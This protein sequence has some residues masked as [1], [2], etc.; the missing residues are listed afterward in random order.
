MKR[1][2]FNL[3]SVLLFAGAVS[4]MLIR[5]QYVLYDSGTRVQN[6]L[7]EY[8]NTH[9]GKYPP[10]FNPLD[11][12]YVLFDANGF[13]VYRQSL[14]LAKPPAREAFDFLGF[15]PGRFVMRYSQWRG[16]GAISFDEPVDLRSKDDTFGF[17]VHSG[18]TIAHGSSFWCYQIVVPRWFL[19]LI[20]TTPAF[21][22][23]FG[24]VSR[25]IREHCR[26]REHRC[27]RCGYD[28]RASPDRCPECG[29]FNHARQSQI[30]RS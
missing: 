28:L 22:M 15:Q 1:R 30:S 10:L 24:A 4:L 26:R 21:G 25:G 5:R 2:L 27:K 14:S 12:T 16:M 8:R 13:A 23:A 7:N 29:T 6:E 19:I 18:S 20:A 9:Q 17:I 3:A 11:A